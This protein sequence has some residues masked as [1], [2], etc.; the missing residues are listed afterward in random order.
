[1]REKG[2]EN[3][4]V[5]DKQREETKRLLGKKVMREEERIVLRIYEEQLKI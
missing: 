3:D 2:A 1:M 4:S 5:K